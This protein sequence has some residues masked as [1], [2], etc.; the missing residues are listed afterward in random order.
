MQGM[1]PFNEDNGPFVVFSGTANPELAADVVRELNTLF[2]NGQ[3]DHANHHFPFIHLGERSITHFQ[4]NEVHIQLEHSVR[5]RDVYI[6]QSTCPPVNEHLMEIFIMLDTLRRAN[7]ARVTAIIPYYGYAR[8]ERKTKGREPITAKL[9]ANLLSTAGADRV[10]SVDLHSPAIQ[11]FFDIGMDHLIG[12]PI[13]AERVKALGLENRVVVSPDTGGV[14]RAE[15]FAEL[16]GLPLAIL[17]KQRSGD[18]AVAIRAVIGDVAGKCP[19]LIDDMITGGSTIRSAVEA[20]VA[21]GA[22]QDIIV[23]AT[24]PVMVGDAMKNLNHPAITHVI[25]T[26]SIPIAPVKREALGARLQIVSLAPLLAS[27]ILR[28][29]RGQSLSELFRTQEEADPF[30]AAV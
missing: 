21:A 8:Q 25:V 10:L 20:L 19:I 1:E 2:T 23:A 12:A 15:Q 29:H 30:Y 27:A 5:G 22:R 28:L 4:D 24:H 9:I 13:L 16:L 11:G 7:A 17:H 6:I 14:K 18:T 3:E 26:D